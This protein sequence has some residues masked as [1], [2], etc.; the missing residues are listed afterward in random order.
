MIVG[1]PM[2]L[3]HL[4]RGRSARVLRIK[5]HNETV[6]RLSELGL[7]EG[8]KVTMIRKAPFG[9]PIEIELMNYRLVLRNEEA[10]LVEVEPE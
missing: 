2:S 1:K 4:N 8:E 5:E 9:D 6:D 10:D 3:K 7:I